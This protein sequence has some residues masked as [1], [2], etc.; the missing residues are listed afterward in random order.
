MITYYFI[1]VCLLG[2]TIFSYSPTC[3]VLL[4]KLLLQ[5]TNEYSFEL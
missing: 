5:S 2:H 4:G 3:Q 1:L